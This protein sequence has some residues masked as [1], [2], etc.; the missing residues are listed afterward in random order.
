MI[1]QTPEYRK[2]VA[3]R[4]CEGCTKCCEGYLSLVVLGNELYK[5]GCPL[6]SKNKGCT[7]HDVRPDECRDFRCEWLKNP[8]LPDEFKPSISD[9]IMKINDDGEKPYIF[10]IKAG[11]PF[12]DDFIEKVKQLVEDDK[13]ERIEFENTKKGVFVFSKDK[14]WKESRLDGMLKQLALQ[15]KYKSS[16][17]EKIG[18]ATVGL[19]GTVR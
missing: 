1:V 18:I 9:V 11:R 15:N 12:S 6:V 13:I 5:N 7:I 14:E 17:L 4:S 10:A 2:T 16:A 8:N 19:F 3:G